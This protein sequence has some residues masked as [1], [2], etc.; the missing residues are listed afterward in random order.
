MMKKYFYIVFPGLLFGQLVN[1]QQSRQ[2]LNFNKNWKFFLGDTAVASQ[3]GFNDNNWRT[4]SLPHDWSIEGTFSEKHPATNQGGALPGGI[5]WYRKTF[6]LPASAKGKQVRIEFD[7]IYRNSEVWINGHYLGKRPYGY[8]SFQYD[9]MPY[10]QTGT[11]KNVLAVKVDN[12]AQ[13]NSRWYSGSGIYRNVRLVITNSIAVDHWGSFVTTPSVNEQ[14]AT[15]RVNTAIR[16]TGKAQKIKVV[17]LLYSKDGKLVA[18]TTEPVTATDSITH[19]TQTLTVTKPLLWSIEQPSLYKAV[20]RLLVNEKVTDEYTTPFGI[21]SFR[22]DLQKGF[23]LNEKPMKILGVCMHHDLGALGAAINVAAMR[24]QLQILKEM[25]CN[26]I[27]TAH[28][29][30][31]PELLDLCDS[32]GFLVMDEAFDMWHKK[33]N[34]YDYSLDFDQWHQL[35]LEDMVKRDRNHPSVIMWSIGNE[36]REQFDSTGIS[37]TRELVR[38]VKQLDTTRPVIAALTEL[39]TTKNFMYQANALDLLGLNYNH[40]IYPEVPQR[41]PGKKFLA[42][43]TNSALASRGH[44]DM[45]SDSIRQWPLKGQKFVEKGNPDFTVSAYDHVTAYWGSTHEATWKVVKQYDFISGLFVWSGFDFLGEPV[46]YPWPARSSYYGIIDLAGIPKDVYYMYQSEWTT[47]TVL[48]I[49]PHWNW[50]KGQPVDVWAYYNNADEV[51][52]FLNNRSL[53]IRKKQPGDLH[54][55]WRVEYEPGTLTAISR[56]NGKNVLTKSIQTASAPARLEL[57]PDKK[58]L[59]ANGQDLSFVTIRVVDDRGNLVP[60]AAHQLQ[61]EIKGEGTFAGADNGYPASPESFKALSHK[62]YSGI[63]VAII[64]SREKAG[65]IQLTVHTKGLPSCTILLQS[66]QK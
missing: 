40:Q 49:F 43:E 42:T 27:R 38:M 55:Q 31:A 59:H 16:H 34:K 50:T 35:D 8:S 57:A 32:M 5:S 62:A 9:L 46:P 37:L 39:D 64:Q 26:A 65:P 52:L 23:F 45:P 24:R 15:V 41:Y 29:P 3:P 19:T 28:N 47:K 53:G 56:K 51:E 44:Y 66:R 18:S 10:C 12:S 20:T 21:R 1:A 36:I 7:G 25:G 13:P 60:D 4:L 14:S 6:T 11:A 30:P 48:H 22:F 2:I 33:K 63:C 58:I 17:I 54:V 61:F